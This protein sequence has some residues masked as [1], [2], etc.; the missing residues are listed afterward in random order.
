MCPEHMSQ[1]GD[2]SQGTEFVLGIAEPKGGPTVNGILDMDR[3]LA[4]DMLIITCPECKDEKH[5]ELDANDTY[6]CGGCG[7]TIT[8][9]TIM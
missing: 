7:R 4:E 3:S 9:P 5:L 8:V 1:H 6:N 2:Y